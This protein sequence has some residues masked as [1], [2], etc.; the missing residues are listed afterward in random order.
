MHI[1]HLLDEREFIDR[2]RIVGDRPIRVHRDCHRA[3]AQKAKRYQAESEDRSSHHQR[4]KTHGAHVITDRH[5]KDHGESQV[6][7]GEIARDKSGENIERG[8][9]F[10]G[11]NHDFFDVARFRGGEDFH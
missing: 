7:A 5:Q 1:G 3:H 10:F 11:G 4:R 2:L 6:V 8:A 9:A